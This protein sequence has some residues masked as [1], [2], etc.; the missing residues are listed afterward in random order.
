[1]KP[2]AESSEQNKQPILD[3]LRERF[4]HPGTV[5]EIGSGT[6]QHAIFFSEQLPHLRWQ[7]SDREENLQGIEL[8]RIDSDASNCLIPIELDVAGSPWPEDEFDYVFSAN[9]CHIMH[10]PEVE[11]MLNGIGAVL[12]AGGICCLYGPFNKNG[13]YTAPSNQRFD[14]WLKER[15]PEMGVRDMEAIR[16]TAAESGLVLK[17]EIAMP[18]DNFILV[19]KKI[20]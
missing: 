17:N 20:G 10:W 6:G 15:D 1:M 14:A 7:P 18:A 2:Y 12:K 3:V 9:T 19:L 8:W 5:L 13:D 4:G 11:K 16:D